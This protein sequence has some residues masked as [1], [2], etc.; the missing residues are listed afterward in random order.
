MLEKWWNYKT[1]KYEWRTQPPKHRKNYIPQDKQMQDMFTTYKIR[2]G[3]DEE[4]AMLACLRN[5]DANRT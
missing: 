4:Q 1:E 5:R 2:Y 3:M